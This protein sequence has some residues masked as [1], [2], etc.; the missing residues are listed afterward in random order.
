MPIGSYALTYNIAHEIWKK[1]PARVVDLGVGFGMQGALIRQYVDQGIMPFKTTLIGVEGFEHYRNPM[2]DIYDLVRIEPIQ[3][4]LAQTIAWNIKTPER[5]Y[6]YDMIIMTDVIEH[7]D[8]EEGFK[9]A[10]DIM[11]LLAP[12]GIALI[13]TPGIF[14]EQGAAYG[15]EFERHRSLWGPYDFPAG[16]TI[17]Q[18][19]SP[20]RDG[21]QMILVKYTKP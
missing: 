1:K 7:F 4:Y 13:G 17:L 16:Y 9:V 5:P 6:L 18:D 11:K 3:L 15:N 2:W 14:Q 20:D 10:Q 21:H 19:G 12:G 8:K